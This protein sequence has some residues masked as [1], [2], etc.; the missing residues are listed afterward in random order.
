V[1]S[2][3]LTGQGGSISI[4]ALA[5]CR[6]QEISIMVLDRDGQAISYLTPPPKRDMELRKAQ[7]TLSADGRLSLARWLIR[8]KVEGQRA[9]LVKHSWLPA[10]QAGADYLRQCLAWWDVPG[11]GPLSS[12]ER[13]TMHEANAA[14]AYFG[15]WQGYPLPWL[16]RDA[17]R[18]PPHYRTIGPRNS[19]LSGTPQKAADPCNAMLN[20]VY[21][22]LVD[23]L[24]RVLLC[25]GFDVDSGIL[26]ADQ[27]DA[28]CYDVMEPLRPQVDDLLL[29]L[30]RHATLRYGDASPL[31]V[32]G[33]RLHVLEPAPNGLCRLHPE[34]MRTLATHVRVSEN[35]LLAASGTLLWR[36]RHGVV[37]E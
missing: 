2:I 4:D 28:L 34:L 18:V 37:A 33:T 20:Y 9:T 22:I 24:R 25:D 26:H 19:P 16:K 32:D 6:A 17:T 5:W 35:A 13:L 30:L 29:G 15:A 31:S 10:A 1:R 8:L 14:G 7:R 12:I 11:C 3:I 21:A 23:D 36:L 27:R